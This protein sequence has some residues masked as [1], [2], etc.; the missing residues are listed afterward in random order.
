[1]INI[2]PKVP[3]T[4]IY[5]ITS[6]SGKIYIGQS[7]NVKKRWD[8][9]RRL[10]CKVQIKL[11]RSLLKYGFEQHKFE[12]IEECSE[13]QLLERE[14]YWKQ[15]YKV[16]EIPSLCCRM[17]GRGGKLSDETK[18]NISNA[19]IGKP[20]PLGMGDKIS[21]SKKGIALNYKRTST[22][23]YNLSQANNKSVNQY[24]LEGNFIKEWPS[25]KEAELYYNPRI[26]LQDNIGACCREKQQTAYG[27]K[28]K[29]YG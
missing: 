22:H 10:D 2:N 19:L 25:L 3:I 9:Y 28:W 7:I 14:T 16:L 24:D 12:I 20:K 29:Y 1:M 5:K 26:K 18:K 11:Y 27:Y 13:D 4:G 15:Y 8:K 17:D 6:P 23:S 21:K